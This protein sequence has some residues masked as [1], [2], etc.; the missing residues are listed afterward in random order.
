MRVLVTRPAREAQRWVV[1]LQGQGV[2]AAALPLLDIGP[3]P[4]RDAVRGAWERLAGVDAVMFV[5]AN[6]VDQFFLLKPAQQPLFAARAWAP[7][8]GTRDALLRAGVPLESIDTPAADA[9]QLDSQALWQQVGNQ[10]G[11][12]QRVLVVRGGD[13]GGKGAGRDW[14]AAQIA[15]RGVAVETVVA[16]TRT[17]PAWSQAQLEL[18]Q[19]GADDGSLWLFSSSEAI[20]NLREL[21]PHHRWEDARAL[22]THPRIAEAASAVGFGVVSLS[23]PTLRDVVASIES[24]R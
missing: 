21:L 20:A 19:R 22:A 18:A 24:I 23:R 16:Y 9:Q 12:G 5:S 2:D 10:L 13:A 3:A 17:A 1:D 7:G 8:P 6:A 15:A 4:D 11:A 14:L